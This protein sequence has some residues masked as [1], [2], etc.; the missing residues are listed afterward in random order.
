MLNIKPEEVVLDLKTHVM[1]PYKRRRQV[2][3]SDLKEYLSSP[4]AA[5]KILSQGKDP[6]IYEYSEHFLL[7]TGGHLTFGVTTIF[8]GKIG[9]E[10][11]MTRGHYHQK[12]TAETYF[13]LSGR[14]L[15]L[16]QTKNGE[17]VFLEL[18]PGVIAYV[19]PGWGHRTV[20]TGSEKLVYFFIYPSDAGHD[21]E[22]VRKGGFAKTIV[23]KNGKPELEDNPKFKPI[24]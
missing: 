14:G 8:P 23:E 12:D 10:Y 4:E 20:N 24:P 21:Y 13:T 2:K 3:L 17:I 22:S 15:L 18:R 16:M 1:Q 11:Y 19:P 5:D 6:I 9:K 7:E